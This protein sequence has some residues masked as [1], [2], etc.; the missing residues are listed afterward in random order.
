MTE[1]AQIV[2]GWPELVALLTSVGYGVVSAVIPLVNAEAYVLASQVSAVA[3][4]VPIGV[5]VGIGQTVGKFLLFYGVRRGR[6]FRFFRHR[7]AKVHD[8]A[9]G[10][11][12]TWLRTVLAKLLALVGDPRWGLP[13]VALAAVVGFPPLY[14]VA[15]LAGATKMRTRWFVLVVLVG[16][17][18]RFV[19]VA[20]FGL[21]VMQFR[22]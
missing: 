20:A 5:G 15:L 16:R 18:T 6:Q 8:A 17:V 21:N 14:A 22:A 2:F 4:A 3:G 9:V 13:M 19:L 7:R 10:R 1:W 11:V 12:R